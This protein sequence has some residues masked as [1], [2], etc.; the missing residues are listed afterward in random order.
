M[1][2]KKELICSGNNYHITCKLGDKQ[3]TK[4]PVDN[5]KFDLSTVNN[6]KKVSIESKKGSYYI[7]IAPDEKSEIICN[8]EFGDYGLELRCKAIGPH[9]PDFGEIWD[10]IVD[11]DEMYEPPE[12]VKETV[13]KLYKETIDK[14]FPDVKDRI[15]YLKVFVI[16]KLK[17]SDALTKWWF[18]DDG[19]VF[20]L[21][22]GFGEKDF[23]NINDDKVTQEKFV[24]DLIHELTHVER[25]MGKKFNP[26]DRGVEEGETVA[27]SLVRGD[28]AIRIHY[29]FPDGDVEQIIY[30][31]HCVLPKQY[32]FKTLKQARE[33]EEF[34]Y[35]MITG[36]SKPK[37][38]NP[39]NTPDWSEIEARIPVSPIVDMLRGMYGSYN[40][41]T[42]VKEYW[43]ILESPGGEKY[44]YTIADLH[45][46]NE[47]LTFADVIDT[48]ESLDAIKDKEDIKAIWDF[49]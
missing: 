35:E 27:E 30:V 38:L 9:T 32:C 12:E 31:K 47:K 26:W 2:D 22:I 1:S 21:Y 4:M 48:V 6:L 17:G 14:S 18:D 40:P 25:I 28:W 33:F 41:I 15:D 44:M 11:M 45:V 5:V 19:K 36:E 16:P 29:P 13:E 39:E 43:V 49:P 20:P 42:D 46:D 7:R 23:D 37:P 8:E 3:F 34:N 10:L 24:L